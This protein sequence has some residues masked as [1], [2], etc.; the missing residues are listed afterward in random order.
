LGTAE[1]RL[2]SKL[3][4]EVAAMPFDPTNFI[5]GKL[6]FPAR[7]RFGADFRKVY[8]RC[9]VAPPE[10]ADFRWSQHRV[11]IEVDLEI[12]ANFF[13]GPGRFPNELFILDDEPGNFS[14]ANAPS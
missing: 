1:S 3:R 8:A 6:A 11:R 10:L 9:G 12:R 2:I 14:V 7:H 4:H 5:F 13:H